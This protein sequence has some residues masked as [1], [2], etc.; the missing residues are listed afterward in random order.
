MHLRSLTYTCLLDNDLSGG[1]CYPTFKQGISQFHWHI[2]TLLQ[3]FGN[4]QKRPH[5]RS[6]INN[7]FIFILFPYASEQIRFLSLFLCGLSHWHKIF[8]SEYCLSHVGTVLIKGT[9]V[10]NDDES[11]VSDHF[12]GGERPRDETVICNTHECP[13]RWV[14]KSTKRIYTSD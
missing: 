4:K 13:A 6:R 10:R 5:G 2:H 1:Y 14:L 7:S 8:G 11:M 12:C 9:C 3:S